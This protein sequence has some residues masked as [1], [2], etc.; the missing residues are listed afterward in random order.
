ME[1]S[2]NSE[3]EKGNKVLSNSEWSKG[4][5]G[6]VNKVSD[7]GIHVKFI[8]KNAYGEKPIYEIFRFQK[9]HRLHSKIEDLQL[10]TGC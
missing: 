9:T 7:I 10:T 5:I 6:V 3:F 2:K 8:E 1:N 4:K